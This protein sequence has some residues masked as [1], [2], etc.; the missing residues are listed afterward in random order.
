MTKPIP[1]KAKKIPYKLEKHGQVRQ[2]DYYWLNDRENP[3]VIDYLNR[4][5][6]YYRQATAHTVALQDALYQEMKGRIKED[7]QS[8]PYFYNGYF[9]IRRFEKGKDYP[10]LSRKKGSLNAPEE[11]MFDCNEMA[12]G[13][14]YF[15]LTGVSVSPDNQLATFS[16][17][18]V[19]RRIYTMQI[20]NLQ[21]GEIL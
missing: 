9:Y 4:E 18:T 20:K 17:D 16:T 8:V 5:N 1:P 10:I 3:E 14:S 12:K 11:I 6:E 13:H 15:N 7:D 2:D 19:G 21:T